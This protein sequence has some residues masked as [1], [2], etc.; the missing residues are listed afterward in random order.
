M[1][2]I[3]LLLIL[4]GVTACNQNEDSQDITNETPS[5]TEN[6]HEEIEDQENVTN[7]PVKQ[8]AKP[9]EPDQ[10][11]AEDEVPPVEPSQ[12]ILYENVAFKVLEITEAEQSI[13]V[14]GKARVFE[15]V[16]QYALISGDNIILQN[17]YQT[18]G[19]PAWG[20]FT[21][22]FK[23][24]LLTTKTSLELFVYSAKDGSITDV[25][26]IPLN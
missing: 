22:S 8:P 19:A 5:V 2:W 15:G 10:S 11:N 7:E 4:F 1:L 26:T 9:E 18:D 17:F 3:S 13:I 25:L 24:E 6:E 16:F 21:L 14:T 23:K 20:N 12:E